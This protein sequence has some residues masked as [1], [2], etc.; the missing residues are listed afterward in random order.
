MKSFDFDMFDKAVHREY[1]L[2]QRFFDIAEAEVF[3]ECCKEIRSRIQSN[4]ATDADMVE[5]ENLLK[6]NYS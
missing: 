6:R 3:K 5:V 4:T 2:I 1:R